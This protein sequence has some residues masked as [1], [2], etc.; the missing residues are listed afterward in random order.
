MKDG[1]LRAM[2][3][4]LKLD[5]DDY[6]VDQLGE[7]PLTHARCSYYPE[8]PR[9]ELVFGL[10][11]HSDG[12]VVTV[13]MVDDTVGGLQVLRDGVWWDVPVVP[14]TLLAII[15]DQIQVRL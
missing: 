8:C 4:L 12:T 7:R 3:K 13:L 14:N 9:P 6:F 2:A 5:D 1:L 10:K 11:P 15:G